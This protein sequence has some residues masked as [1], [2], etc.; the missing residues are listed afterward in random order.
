MPW[1]VRTKM[2]QRQ[3]FVVDYRS[4]LY[5]MSELCERYGVSRVTGYKWLRR[6]EELG[7]AGLED[8]AP[9]AVNCPHATSDEV[10]EALVAFRLKH[11][12]WGSRK[13]LRKLRGRNPDWRWPAASTATEVFRRAGLLEPRLRR[14]KPEHPG[15]PATKATEPNELWAADFKGQ[16]RMGDGQYCYPLTV[17]D[18]YSRYLLGC[19]GLANVRTS[20]ARAVFERLFREYGLPRAIR[21][22]NGSPFASTAIGRLSRLSVWWI[23]LGVRPELIEPGHPEQNGAHERMHRTMKKKLR[24]P[25]WDL[26]DQQKRLNGFRVEYN[27]E[28]PHEALGQET[29]ASVYV[30]SPRA[31]PRSLPGIDYPGHFEVRRVSRNGGVRWKKNWLNVSHALAEEYVGFEEVDDGVW[32]LHFG[33]LLLA[34][35]E[36]RDLKL[37]G[38]KPYDSHQR[39]V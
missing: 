30:S 10:R 39:E 34:R 1:D 4:G 2:R 27:E 32:S 18:S 29:P 6:C 15:R 20:G 33:P 9:I 19:R 3:E 12:D 17:T 13:V 38:A 16:F 31:F 21:T 37:Y 7:W 11:P 22:D 28:R 14:R 8:R 36:E 24:P 23:R 26:A 5:G 35:F 25:G